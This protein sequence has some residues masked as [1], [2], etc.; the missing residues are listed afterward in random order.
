MNNVL[1]IHHPVRIQMDSTR[2]NRE[3][4]LA[5]VDDVHVSQKPVLLVPYDKNYPA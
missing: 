1:V 5:P 4:K 2:D 3:R